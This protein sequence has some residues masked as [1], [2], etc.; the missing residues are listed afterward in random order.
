MDLY[1]L[2]LD[3]PQANIACDQALLDLCEDGIAGEVLRFWESPDHFAVLGYSSTALTEVHADVCRAR[4]IP[5][6][7][8]SSGGGAVLQGPGCLNYSLIL[9]IDESGPLSSITGT[10]RHILERHSHALQR[11]TTDP[12]QLQGQS[13]LTIRG[14]K[15]SGNAQRRQQRS[16]LFHGTVLYAFD[17]T[18]L[19]LLLPMPLRQPSYR[20]NR[21]HL[22]FITNFPA[23]AAELRDVLR[24]EWRAVA[25]P[26]PDL[27]GR[28]TS[29][30]R[31]RY[32]DPAWTFRR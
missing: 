7:R 29:L 16:V 32:A 9:R 11:L 17:L 6:V 20:A 31:G 22:D 8:R 4:H 23:A 18:L 15:F 12:I 21:P 28:V 1:D 24:N 10:T 3:S 27:S 5:L 13:D 26:P 2:T 30:V 25:C 14:L 19:A